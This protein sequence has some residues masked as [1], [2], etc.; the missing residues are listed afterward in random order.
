[1]KFAAFILAFVA[2]FAFNVPAQAETPE[3]S[4][5]DWFVG[6]KRDQ[7]RNIDG[8]Q[9]ILWLEA[10]PWVKEVGNS[11]RCKVWRKGRWFFPR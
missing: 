5:V 6:I 1:M 8:N 3:V 2:P 11:E 9:S 7:C 4:G 10:H